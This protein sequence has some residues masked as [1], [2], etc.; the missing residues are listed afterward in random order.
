MDSP[1]VRN[2][3]LSLFIEIKPICVELT[4]LVLL[5]TDAL[6]AKIFDINHK[7]RSL[8]TKLQHH[9]D[10]NDADCYVVSPKVADYIFFPITNLLK[11]PSLEPET[12]R[13]ILEIIAF[14][15]KNS[16]QYNL[17]V[18]L[19]DQLCPLI[20]LLTGGTAVASSKVST[21][22][23]KDFAFKSAAVRCI[24]SL[25]NCLPRQYFQEEDKVFARLSALGDITTIL[26]DV[27]GS[28]TS[29]VNQED[30]ELAVL[31]LN[32][33][34]SLYYTRV[35]PEQAS[36]VFPGVVSK[37][38]NFCITVKN[39]Q[40][41]TLIKVLRVLKIF[42]TK[43]FSDVD[44]EAE[45]SDSLVSPNNLSD[46]KSLL[47]DQ[48]STPETALDRIKISL[49]VQSDEVHRT[50]SWLKATSKQL[51]L[52]MITLFRSLFFV[53]SSRDKLITKTQLQDAIFEFVQDIANRC[54]KTLFNELSQSSLDILSA[55]I[56]VAR[57]GSNE[58][59]LFHRARGIYE[60]L[61]Y[62][63]INLLANQLQVKTEDLVYNQ[64]PTVLKSLNEERINVCSVAVRLHIHILRSLLS[65]LNKDTCIISDLDQKLLDTVSHSLFESLSRDHSKKYVATKDDLL[66]ML[67]GQNI[68]NGEKN[69]LDEIELPSHINAKRLTKIKKNTNA[70]TPTQVPN[71]GNLDLDFSDSESREKPL[72]LFNTSMTKET[73]LEIKNLVADISKSNPKEVDFFL[74]SLMS[75]ETASENV[76][77]VLLSESIPLWVA[78]RLYEQVKSICCA[79]EFDIDSFLQLDGED[80]GSNQITDTGSELPYILL[81]RAQSL[82]SLAK[83][84]ISEN[85]LETGSK[86]YNACDIALSVSLETIGSL[87]RFLSKSD[88]QTDVLMDWLFPILE[89]LTLPEG[90]AAHTQ[91]KITVNQIV[92]EFYNGSLE[93]LIADNS[94]YLIDSLSLSLSVASGLTPALPGILLIVLKISGK[95]LLETNQ[96]QDI[97][98]EM[99]IVIDTYHGYSVLVENFFYVFEEII[100]KVNSIYIN[101]VRKA[102]VTK[103][104]PVYKPWG[105]I[106]RE[107][108]F[109]LI[110]DA[111]KEVDPF[112]DYDPEKEYFKRKPGIPFSDQ[113]DSDDEGDSDDEDETEG[114]MRPDS[115]ETEIWPSLIP[116]G[117]Y[118]SVQQI[119][120]YGLQL[121]SHPSTK[122]KIQVLRT[123]KASYLL[124]ASNYTVLMPILAHH[125][126]I[127]LLIIAGTNTI[128][129]Y[130]LTDE[131]FQQHQLIEPILELAIVIF[132]EDNKHQL[133]M[134]RRF[135]EMWEYLKQKSPL[136]GK[137]LDKTRNSNNLL[138]SRSSVSPNVSRLTVKLL[139]TGLNT[140]ERTIPDMVAYEIAKACVALGI[141]KEQKLG[142]DARNLVWVAKY[143]D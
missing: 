23:A 46:L 33:L 84:Q 109:E 137:T 135:T 60:R 106:D 86:E 127:I 44:L 100:R 10:N 99:F 69:A 57:K 131:L 141:D 73:Q 90:S 17:D 18:L 133:F 129:D 75:L 110:D 114:S 108:M 72:L 96:L 143:Q 30:N 35:T 19:V 123:L 128:T 25:I 50:E 38:V 136:F 87:P 118:S 91:A 78:N 7:L 76:T 71:L 14:L 92:Q 70:L 11:H 5:P 6:Q 89:A 22:V 82:L 20:V 2:L 68:E 122:L 85:M 107:A 37:L 8:V 31:V 134:S 4:E 95:A 116:K 112:D 51:K 16:W 52:S 101:D 55:L 111:H 48:K 113:V 36:Y 24:A 83:K 21:I 26:L 40:S 80:D 3:S 56:F 29:P 53:P 124:M 138:V 47:E 120:T 88:F 39:V 13:Y 102:I 61:S 117:I 93:E 9:Y 105:L 63:N 1:E 28:F 130:D 121:L 97:L 115:P 34:E 103:R 132:E 58:N 74:S 12:P 142:R 64:F 94:D 139:L 81:E 59:E 43:V 49:P 98:S 140:Y 67:S 27:I 62:S 79:E 15:T 42:I 32:S 119:F 65:I 41:A 45:I 125:W 126:P 66:K 77:E 104:D 54:F